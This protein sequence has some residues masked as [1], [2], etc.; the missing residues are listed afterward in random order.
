MH[1]RNKLVEIANVRYGRHFESKLITCDSA[2]PQPSMPMARMGDVASGKASSFYTGPVPS[3]PLKYLVKRGDIVVSMSGNFNVNRWNDQD[4]LLDLRVMR[5][6]GKANSSDTDYLYHCL[7]PVFKRIEDRT[8]GHR[9]KN[10]TAKQVNEI[11]VFLPPFKEQQR[12]AELLNAH[13]EAI[14]A[15]KLQI[16]LSRLQLSQERDRLFNMEGIG[17]TP[18]G[19]LC[20]HT[21]GGGTPA[22]SHP[23]YYKGAIP[24]LR[25]QEVDW[26]EITDTEVKITPEAIAHSQ[27][28]LVP[29]GCVIVAMYGA[30]AGKAAINRIPLC[31]N[32]ACCS[33]QIDPAMALPEYVFHFLAREHQN[34]KAL[35]EGPRGNLNATKIKNY[36]IPLPSVEEQRRIVAAI[37]TLYNIIRD[38]ELQVAQRIQQYEDC[39]DQLGFSYFKF[40]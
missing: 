21:Y 10:L 2:G 29:E 4:A 22:T 32:Q 25:T 1:G 9:T 20:L 33:L 38:L 14:D 6:R 24:W 35:G 37:D 16:A 23:E 15:L 5:I 17:M 27:A 7:Q 28:E 40:F 39:R 11:E 26:N 18:L 12:L 30:T 36:P 34:L 19:S 8:E 31:T 13:T 3:P